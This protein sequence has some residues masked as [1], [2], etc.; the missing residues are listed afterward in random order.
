MIRLRARPT[1]ARPTAAP[2]GPA[3][4]LLLSLIVAALVVSA[5]QLT[6]AWALDRL[7]GGRDVHLVWTLRLHLTFNRGMAFSRGGGLG[8]VIAILAIVVVAVLVGSLRRAG[9]RGTLAAVAVGLVVGGAAGNIA[10]RVARSG[11][12]FLGGAVVDFIDLQWWPVFNLA[13]AAITVGGALLL[14]TAL[15]AE[16]QRPAPATRPE[17]DEPVQG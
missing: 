1:P 6:K 14:L 16:R 3:P 2:R 9:G 17:R 13:D 7:A 8:P 12:G 15:R 11:E 5:D 4:H 10:D